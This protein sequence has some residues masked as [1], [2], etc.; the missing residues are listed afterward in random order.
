MSAAA[1]ATAANFS[2]LHESYDAYRSV[3]ASVRADLAG[4]EIARD[5]VEPGFV[6]TRQNS[7]REYFGYIVASPYLSAADDFG[8]AGLLAG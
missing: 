7:G 5:R 8:C 3:S 1:A 2:T 4:L 6:L